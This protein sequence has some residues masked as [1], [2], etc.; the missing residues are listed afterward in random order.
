MDY[1]RHHHHSFFWPVILVGVGVIW[2]LVNLGVIAPISIGTIFQ[3][4]PILLIILGLDILFGRSFAWIGGLIGV[5]AVGG[6]VAFL[7]LFPAK[8]ANI[9]TQSTQENHS[10]PLAETTSVNY[11][12]ETASEPVEISPLKSD[13]TQLIDADLTHLGTIDFNVTGNAKKTVSLSETSNPND[14][15]NWNPIN[16]NLKWEIGLATGIPT[17]ITIDGGSGSIHADFTGV[18]LQSLTADLGS[19]SSNFTLPQ[20]DQA[21]KV[22]LNSGSGSVDFSLPEKTNV[23]LQLQS[24]SGSF[25]II[26]P[27]NSVARVEVMNSGSGSLN[28]PD[29]LTLVSGDNSEGTW[30][31]TV[32]ENAAERI[33]IQILD[34]GS[35]SITI[36]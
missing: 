27:K 4:W 1:P 25:N 3:F 22:N 21:I 20:S 5:L 24:G 7:I 16:T 17:D 34:R 19:G 18:K 13:S 12:F 2:L 9:T 26:L 28:L 15:F 32:Y 11:E 14:W 36:N 23:T 33:L 8:A 29:S 10:V 6:L 30:Q 35:G 31:S